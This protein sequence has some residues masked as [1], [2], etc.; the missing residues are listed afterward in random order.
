M[1]SAV[2]LYSVATILLLL[3]CLSSA[4]GSQSQYSFFPAFYN[5]SFPIGNL[6]GKVVVV[7]GDSRGQ[8]HAICTELSSRGAIVY[9][10]SRTNERD[11]PNLR[12]NHVTGD[13]TSVSDVRRLALRLKHDRVTVNYQ[14]NN[15]GEL[16][17]VFDQ[18]QNPE[19]LDVPYQVNFLG[20]YRV[21]DTLRRAG[22]FASSGVRIGWTSSVGA[23]T[24][25]GPIEAYGH[26]KAGIV[27]WVKRLA[28]KSYF[29]GED[30]YHFAILPFGVQ[31]NISCNPYKLCILD[32]VCQEQADALA[33]AQCPLPPP[34]NGITRAEDVAKFYA[35]VLTVS[36]PNATFYVIDSPFPLDSNGGTYQSTWIPN[37]LNLSPKEYYQAWQNSA[38]PYFYMING[39]P[40]KCNNPPGRSIVPYGG[41]DRYCY[42]V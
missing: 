40:A 13:I 1:K 26:S 42:S 34:G 6:T 2:S 31:T 21:Y 41:P 35:H 4:Y 32:E 33:P 25:F 38:F 28:I 10:I 7:T 24:F 3:A 22:L 15:A 29:Y 5:S 27:D 37:W 9:G 14:I 11:I 16:N 19:T 30:T 23:V 39:A 18:D 20:N 12:W 8:G 17:S 36:N